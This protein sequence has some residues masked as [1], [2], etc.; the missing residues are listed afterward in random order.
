MRTLS[1]DQLNET[2]NDQDSEEGN[3][4][5]NSP[6]NVALFKTLEKKWDFMIIMLSERTTTNT[7]RC[8]PILHKLY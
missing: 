5:K 1:D 4:E 7:E 6:Y 8:M 3:E 2:S